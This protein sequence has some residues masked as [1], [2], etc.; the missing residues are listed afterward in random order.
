M[1]LYYLFFL[2]GETIV[3]LIIGRRL[4][5]PMDWRVCRQNI[6]LSFEINGCWTR[7]IGGNGYMVHSFG[8]AA[9]FLR[10]AEKKGKGMIYLK[11]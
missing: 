11:K 5:F 3:G 10:L 8:G 9:R 7:Q 1:G 2:M 6:E 4:L